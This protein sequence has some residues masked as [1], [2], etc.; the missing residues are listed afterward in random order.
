[1]RATGGW[2]SG[3]QPWAESEGERKLS[4]GVHLFPSCGSLKL[5]GHRQ[6]GS[7]NKPSVCHFS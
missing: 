5:G 2:C 6:T 7:Q 4:S 3:L 1:M